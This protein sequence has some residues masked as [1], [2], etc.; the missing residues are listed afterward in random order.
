MSPTGPT[1]IMDLLKEEVI[2]GSRQ[3]LKF[4]YQAWV[5]PENRGLKIHAQQGYILRC[6]I[7]DGRCPDFHMVMLFLYHTGVCGIT[8]SAHKGR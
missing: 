4:G 5:G 8:G 2:F 1:F 6:L 7:W 3:G